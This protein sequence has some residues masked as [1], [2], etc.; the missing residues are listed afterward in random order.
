MIVELK[1]EGRQKARFAI[2]MDYFFEFITL[3]LATNSE[4]QQF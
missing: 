2:Y 3:T 1:Q 4:P